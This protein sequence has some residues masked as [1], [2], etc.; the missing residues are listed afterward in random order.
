MARKSHFSHS[1]SPSRP[2]HLGITLLRTLRPSAFSQNITAYGLRR[3]ARGRA[4]SRPC[5][6]VARRI[7]NIEYHDHPFISKAWVVIR[8]A[9]QGCMSVTEDT[10]ESC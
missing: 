3:L 1:L 9:S 6:T 8:H 2:I 5:D 4:N 7:A 10:R